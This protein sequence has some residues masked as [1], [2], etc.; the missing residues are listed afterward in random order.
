MYRGRPS[1][2]CPWEG[3]I[4]L[5]QG[6]GPIGIVGPISQ[7]RGTKAPRHSRWNVLVHLRA[8]SEPTLLWAA[9]GVLCPH[10][11]GTVTHRAHSEECCSIYYASSALNETCVHPNLWPSLK[12]SKNPTQGYA[13]VCLLACLHTQPNKHTR[14]VLEASFCDEWFGNH[15]GRI[16]HSICL[17]SNAY[18]T[19]WKEVAFEV[20]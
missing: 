6:E 17:S 20:D 9:K 19:Q 13:C 4:Q 8:L 12:C 2:N 10:V 1:W 15:S 7:P 11:G 16:V 14:E 18:T 3:A 5:G